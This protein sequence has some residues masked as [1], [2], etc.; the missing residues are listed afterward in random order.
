MLQTC[1]S[2][3]L[4]L[5]LFTALIFWGTMVKIHRYDEANEETSKEHIDNHSALLHF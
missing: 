5:A 2:V 4:V 1:F 3:Y